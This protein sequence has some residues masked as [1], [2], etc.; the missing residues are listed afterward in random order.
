VLRLLRRRPCTVQEV[1]AAL[2]LH[3]NEATKHVGELERSGSVSL[4][5]HY[6]VAYYGLKEPS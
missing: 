5:A 4:K 3:P 1:A 2:S 6:G